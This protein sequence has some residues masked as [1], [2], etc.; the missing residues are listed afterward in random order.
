MKTIIKRAAALFT[1]LCMSLILP[2]YASEAL[3]ARAVLNLETNQLVISGTAAS[4]KGALPLILEIKKDDAV[5]EVAQTTS[6]KSVNGVVSFSFP[7]V[8]FPGNTPSGDYSIY[9]SA[10]YID[11]DVSFTYRHLGADARLTALKAVNQGIADGEAALL[12][13]LTSHQSVLGM[14]EEGYSKLSAAAKSLLAKRL[15]AFGSYT[16]PSDAVTEAEVEAITAAAQS[17]A[18]HYNDCFM[19]AQACDITTLQELSVFLDAY[20]QSRGLFAEE[21]D[22]AYSEARMAAYFK[23]AQAYEKLAQKVS[24]AAKQSA[25]AK[26][27]KDNF[28][29]AGVLT[30]L[31]EGRYTKLQEITEALLAL[32]DDID[33]TQYKRVSQNDLPKVYQ[34]L[35]DKSYDSIESFSKALNTAV[36]SVLKG[37]SSSDRTNTGGGNS[38]GSGGGKIKSETVVGTDVIQ[39]GSSGFSDLENYGWAETAIRALSDKGVI[40][41]RSK[42]I[43]DPGAQVTR[44]EFTKMMVGAFGTP[45]AAYD[46]RYADVS[47]ESWY[48]PYVAAATA[49]GLVEGSNGYFDPNA[50]ITREDM[51]VILCRAL[52]LGKST[53]EK[54][55]FYDSDAISGYAF[56]AVFALYEKGIVSGVGEGYFAPKKQASRAEAATMIYKALS[57]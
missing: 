46:G 54:P 37:G 20:A 18:K 51:A 42:T 14:D 9:V 45:E 3:T 52:G 16:L 35:T 22:T 1:M 8:Y 44:A 27:F 23:E 40:A 31:E 17:F 55:V 32:F 30:M 57:A 39:G 24:A 48:A 13:A 56:E 2:A 41:G 28:L 25:D 21:D 7:G 47:G 11:A 50:C 10:D 12:A 49:A 38:G 15:A 53:E 34:K 36:E 19:L 26:A 5:I 4:A 29:R 6:G 33:T 43:F